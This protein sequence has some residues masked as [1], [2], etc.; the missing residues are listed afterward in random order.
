MKPERLRE[1]LLRWHDGEG[2]KDLPWQRQRTPY[3][4]WVSEIMLQ[5]TQVTT[6]IPYFERFMAAFPTVES[7]AR[8]E[9]DQVLHLWA[10][11]GYYARARNLHRAARLLQDRFQGRFPERLESLCALPGVGRS[12]A[13][14]IL[15]LAFDRPAPILDGNV[16]R[17][18]TRLHGIETW[19]GERA[20]ERLLW[21]L[22]ERYLPDRNAAVH[23]QAL[24]DF[25]ATLCTRSRPKCDRCPF[26]DHCLAHRHGKVSEIPAPRPKVRKPVKESYWLVLSDGR[27]RL[28]LERR[29][30]NGVWAGLWSFPSWDRREA[31]EDHCL[32]I[33]L[34]TG[35]LTWLAPRRHTFTHFQL[36]YVPVLAALKR[37][38][39]RVGDTPSRWIVPTGRPEVAVPS[40]VKKLLAE[41]GS[42]NMLT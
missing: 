13:G 2:R 35:A 5:Q 11:L 3:R 42:G 41:L 24:M 36:R 9:L 22:S 18:W 38:V 40:P 19:P 37:A 17:L 28:Y 8:A 15:S 21:R 1:I 33:G 25:G 20:T 14:A 39:P 34:E 4:V 23:T 32:D 6:V 12:T 31:L 10:G 16:R 29:P 27:E 26:R 30:A 7:L